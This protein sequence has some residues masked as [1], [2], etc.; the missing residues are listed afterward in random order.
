M[1]EKYVASIQEIDNDIQ[2]RYQHFIFEINEDLRI[3][4]DVLDRAFS[5]D[6]RDAYLGSIELAKEMGVPEDEIIDSDAKRYNY[7]LL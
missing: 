5:V 1:F 4:V 3:F 6:V 2:E 7:F